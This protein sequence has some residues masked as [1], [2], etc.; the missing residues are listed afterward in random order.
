MCAHTHTHACE[1]V[2]GC[3]RGCAF[4][5]VRARE[6]NGTNGA[7]LRIRSVCARACPQTRL[8]GWVSACASWTAAGVRVCACARVCA[9]ACVR[10]RSSRVRAAAGVVRPWLGAA[11]CVRLCA[12]IGVRVEPHADPRP[13]ACM[14]SRACVHSRVRLRQ[15]CA[16]ACARAH[17]PRTHRRM[18][19]HVRTNVR[20][21]RR[22]C[23]REPNHRAAHP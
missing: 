12:R 19:P 17:Q 4:V 18:R 22:G 13:R 14:R 10:V 11:A 5:C 9:R 21:S 7:C 20:P 23:V 16:S 1:C 6:H 2:P 3:Q 8:R 15:V